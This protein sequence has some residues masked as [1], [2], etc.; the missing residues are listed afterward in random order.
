MQKK[1]ASVSFLVVGLLL[2][3]ASLACSLFSPTPAS[4]AGTPTAQARAATNTAYAQ[5]QAALVTEIPSPTPTNTPAITLT[6]RTPTPTLVPDGPWLVYPAADGSGLQAYD[7]EAKQTITI[8][9]PQPIYANDLQKAIPSNGGTFFIRAGSALNTDELGIYQVNLF[10]GEVTLLTPLLSIVLQRQIVNQVGTRALDALEVVTGDDA[11]AWSPNERYLAFLAALDGDSS[12]IYIYDTFLDRIHRI[13]GLYS[14]SVLP[15]WSQQ[16]NWLVYQELVDLQSGNTGRSE[17]VYIGAVPSYEDQRSIYLPPAESL[18]EVFL[19]WS[20][21]QSFISYSLTE[22]FPLSLRLVNIE[23]GEINL[24]IKDQFDSAAFDPASQTLAVA[25]NADRAGAA[26]LAAGIYFLTPDAAAFELQRAGVWESLVWSQG[27]MFLSTGPQGALA[28]LPTGDGILLADER[29]TALSPN[30]SW[31]LGWGDGISSPV[32]LRLYQ[33][34]SGNFM[35]NITDQAIS[36]IVW[37]PDSKGFFLYSE[38]ALY[39]VEFPSLKLKLIE[40]GF[41]PGKF[42]DFIWIE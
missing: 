25:V 13:S 35:Q 29:A 15:F 38:D 19:G 5:T 36:Q 1:Q 37:Q 14:Q 30:G 27:G 22:T 7:L 9:L 33:G 26:G 11:L 39:H 3:A 21:A 31:L 24:F 41:E 20:N 40:A 6:T 2:L 34:P 8:A 23:T 16:S 4:W 18:Q 10:S 42:L 17:G 32:G 28:L 12:D